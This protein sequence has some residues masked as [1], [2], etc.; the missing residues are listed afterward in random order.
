MTEEEKYQRGIERLIDDYFMKVYYKEDKVDFDW[1]L[2]PKYSPEDLMIAVRGLKYYN[3]TIKSPTEKAL[4]EAYKKGQDSVR[5]VR[6]I[7]AFKE[8]TDIRLI[9]EELVVK[10]RKN[11]E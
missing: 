5:A 3:Q 10:E 1:V 11:D 8:D 9:L 7:D 6:T 4:R 2:N